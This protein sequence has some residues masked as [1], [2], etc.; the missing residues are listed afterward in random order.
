[1]SSAQ[2][3]HIDEATD[4]DAQLAHL[5]ELL[6]LQVNEQQAAQQKLL[7]DITTRQDDLSRRTA[8][9]SEVLREAID[10]LHERGVSLAEALEPDILKGVKRT[11]ETEPDV[12]AGALYPVLGPAVRKLVASL[13][14]PSNITKGAPY[15][16][17]QLLLIH[18]E[19][20]I[21]LSQVV[22]ED[23]TTQDA[24]IVSGMLDAIRHFVQE[25]FA[26]DNFDGMNT[27]SIGDIT[28]WVEWGP[29][30]VL[31]VVIRGMATELDR[32]PFVEILERI[33]A[34]Y[35]APL[36]QFNGE[37]A[38]F[39]PI[40]ADLESCLSAQIQEKK[41][42]SLWGHRRL[43]SI[44]LGAAVL[45][46]SIAFVTNERHSRWD[47]I[48]NELSSTPGLVV[49]NTE[50]GWR[51]SRIQMLKDPQARSPKLVLLLAGI[52][53]SDLTLTTHAFLSAENEIVRRRTNQVRASTDAS[54]EPGLLTSVQ[55]NEE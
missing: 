1:M 46:T 12:M 40:K 51:T 26:V 35:S 45:F 37:L 33:H 50:R 6:L 52:D 53:P 22:V 17:E 18:T 48:L 55:S 3:Q 2:R 49:L 44:I 14:E 19:S 24:D 30:A 5:R 43:N 15:Q 38:T 9:V 20:S 34:Q 47:S 25:A 23:R 13:F 16:I 31:A 21:V 10:H 8:D 39:E 11:F 41:K 32:Q 4:T 27:L 36:D 29:K 42:T 28:V 54:N 7:E